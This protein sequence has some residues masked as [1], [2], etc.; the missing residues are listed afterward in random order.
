MTEAS[1][2]CPLATRVGAVE[3]ALLT[4]LTDWERMRIWS[5]QLLMNR[6]KSNMTVTS[7][8][9]SA[10]NGVLGTEK[11]GSWITGLFALREAG[12]EWDGWEQDKSYCQPCLF[13]FLE[14]HT[15]RWFLQ[16]QLKCMF[17]PK[18]ALHCMLT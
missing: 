11:Q 7:P 10:M 5:N 18:F 16:E 1:K 13:K 8:F 17:V 6:L 2:Q 9:S 14:D 3:L 12:G 4:S 15:W